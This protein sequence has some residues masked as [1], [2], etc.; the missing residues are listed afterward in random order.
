P[1][2]ILSW[3]LPLY[4]LWGIQVR[5]HLLFIIFVAAELVRGASAGY[6]GHSAMAMLGLFG[7]VLL[8]EYGHSFACRRVGG[9]A[10]EILLWPLG[11]L[12]YCAPPHNWKANLVTTLG[13]PAVNVVL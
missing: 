2:N 4:R 10:D 1:G 3:S 6:F 11:G 7:L 13:G 5:L 9:D 12:A 8:H